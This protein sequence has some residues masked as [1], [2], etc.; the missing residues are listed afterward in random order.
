MV[1]FMSSIIS[2]AIS[3]FNVGLIDGIVSVWLKAWMLAFTIAFPTLTA[4]TP[5][6]RRLVALLIEEGT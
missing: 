3:I 6:V 2:S 1:L 5:M 4:L